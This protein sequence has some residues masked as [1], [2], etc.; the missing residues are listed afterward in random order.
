MGETVLV[1]LEDQIYEAK[2]TKAK[3]GDGGKWH[4]LLHYKGWGKKVRAS[5]GSFTPPHITQWDEW[6][7]S[8]GLRK[9]SKE[10]A[11]K[12]PKAGAVRRKD[13]SADA[14]TPEAHRDVVRPWCLQTPV[15]TP[16]HQMF[17]DIPQPLKQHL[18][19][20]QAHITSGGALPTLPVQHCVHDIL[21]DYRATLS[22]PTDA[23]TPEEEAA[24]ALG[25]YFD[26]ALP[27]C[28][29]YPAEQA[30]AAEVLC[31]G[32]VLPGRVYGASHLLRLLHK[33]PELLNVAHMTTEALENTERRIN[34]VVAFINQHRGIY[35]DALQ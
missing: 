25:A 29:L 24:L 26:K 32:T 35:L 20:E 10:L 23:L 16:I 5:M 17:L 34:A 28:L 27:K 1:P 3:K 15:R 8:D 2:V 22:K 18:L 12:V 30:Q 6:M 14:G 4:Y 31:N 21:A 9:W 33:L 13:D 11:E 19:D 7:E